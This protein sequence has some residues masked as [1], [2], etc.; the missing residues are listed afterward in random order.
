MKAPA[1]SVDQ[2]AREMAP[3]LAEYPVVAAAY[4]FGS[5]VRGELGDG[6]DVDV[7]LVLQRRGETALDHLRTL[8]ELTARLEQATAPW[9]VDLVVL[10]PQGPL[11]CHRV[12]LEGRLIYEA[13]RARR[14]DFES[15]TYVRAFDFRPTFE[16]ATRGKRAA[17]KRWLAEYRR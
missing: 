11:F 1:L 12:L 10:E 9:P 14:V 2:V 8:G 5:C 6:S 13:D 3:I 16:L 17:L 15:D 4:L 7:G